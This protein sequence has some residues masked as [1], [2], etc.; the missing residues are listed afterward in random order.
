MRHV[1]NNDTKQVPTGEVYPLPVKDAGNTISSNNSTSTVLGAGEIWTGTGEEVSAFGRAGISIW[2]PFGE[3]TNGT[4]TI[5]V[6]RDGVNYGG[7]SRDIPDT[8]IAQPVMWEIV[9]QYFRLKY[10]NGPNT[11]S[12]FVIQTQYSNNGAIFLGQQL[13]DTLTDSITGIATVG[14]LQGKDLSGN[15]HSVQVDNKGAL[16]VSDG[17]DTDTELLQHVH[18]Q[19]H[20]LNARFEEAFQ[21]GI[22]LKDIDDE[23]Y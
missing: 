10:T 12:Q 7:P 14:T 18:A 11:A 5:E 15:Y 21:T 17:H 16:R 4:L 6:S 23:L 9:E 13:S 20:L 1:V 8:T 22:T 2:T 3:K 19:L